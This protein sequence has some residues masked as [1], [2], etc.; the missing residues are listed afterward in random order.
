MS[1]LRAARNAGFPAGRLG[2][3]PVSR[4]NTRRHAACSL[5]FL[6]CLIFDVWCFAAAAADR[7]G[8]HLTK[9]NAWFGSAEAAR[10]GENILSWQTETGGWPKNTDTTKPFTGERAKLQGTFDN[11]AT[12]DEL[13]FL[14]RLVGT[15][16]F[17]TARSVSNAF[18]HGL[19]HILSAQYPNG[20]WPQSAPPPANKYHRH[21][22]FNDHSMVRLMT[23]LREVA[24][25]KRYGFVE[26][27][28]RT[29]A[30]RAFDRGVAC[31]LRCQIQVNGRLTA[32]CAQHDEIDFSPRPAR[33]FELASLSGSESVGLTRLLMSVENP[34]PEIVRAVDAAVAWLESAKLTGLELAEAEDADGRKDK[35]VKHNPAAKPMWARFYEIETGRPIFAGRDG[36]KKYALAEIEHER[37]NGYAWLG[38]WPETLLQ[39][40]YPVWKAKLAARSK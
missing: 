16:A 28:Q 25:D 11:G 31:I 12:T 39:K 10:V 7:V 36:V 19:A 17:S 2:D 3:F 15:P 18:T 26:A 30:Q 24:T 34:S 23:F 21:I 29:A 27:S 8:T 35:L 38:Y 20:G 22:T 4:S 13:R 33:T 5:V 9:P 40:D 37:R 32:W 14:A 6:W 1:A